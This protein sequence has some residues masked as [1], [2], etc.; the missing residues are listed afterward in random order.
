MERTYTIPLRSA[1]RHV[2]R[3]LKAKRAI[4]EVRLFLK[5]HM[6][7]DKVLIGRRLNME[8]WDKGVK[9]PPHHVKVSVTKDKEGVVRAELI[10][11]Q[12]EQK[13]EQVHMNKS[14]GLMDKIKGGLG[15]KDD[16]AAGPLGDHRLH[17]RA[18]AQPER[19]RRR[20]AGD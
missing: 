1:F 18:A 3:Y 11:F 14:E 6:K 20:R 7:S 15:K 19:D 12:Y 2:P 13:V 17:P 9:N 8:V 5:K 16:S 10:N 4:R